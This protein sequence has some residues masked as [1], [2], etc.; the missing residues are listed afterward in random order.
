MINWNVSK[1][2]LKFVGAIIERAIND[3]K[4]LNAKSLR[5]DLIAI[6]KN[7]NPLDL[8]KL[9]SANLFN[10]NHDVYG[11]MKYID[12]KTGRLTNHF[13]PRYSRASK[14]QE[15]GNEKMQRRTREKIKTC[16]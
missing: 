14:I 5:M 7:G 6:H 11:I 1:K 2:D 16:L 10:F 9:L 12:R 8:E 13:L 15:D 4:K 3:N